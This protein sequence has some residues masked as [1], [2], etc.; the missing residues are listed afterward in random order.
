MVL[1]LTSADR[2][3]EF[4]ARLPRT[5]AAVEYAQRLHEGQHRVVDGAPFITHPIE[6]G[7]L[8]YEAGATD[9]CD[10]RGGAARHA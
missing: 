6:V 8:L 10:R 7:M 5:K 4:A 2:T 1:I 9:D 3:P